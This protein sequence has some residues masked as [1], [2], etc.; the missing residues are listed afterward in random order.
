[1]LLVLQDYFKFLLMYWFLN[2]SHAL[3]NVENIYGGV[4]LL[5][6]LQA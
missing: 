3:K 4:L 2:H 5:G 6:K 1:M